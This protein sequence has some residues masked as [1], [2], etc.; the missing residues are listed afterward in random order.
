M[1]KLKTIHDI[2]KEK[3]HEKLI[4]TYV[5]FIQLKTG[6]QNEFVIKDVLKWLDI[7]PAHLYILMSDGSIDP[8]LVYGVFHAEGNV[9]DKDVKHFKS[10]YKKLTKINDISK[11]KKDI[12]YGSKIG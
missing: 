6:Y 4:D 5:R 7:D 9:F 10:L 12:K 11:M 2:L 3:Y 1:I 8:A